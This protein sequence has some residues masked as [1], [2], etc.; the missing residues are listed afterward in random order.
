LVVKSVEVDQRVNYL[1]HLGSLL[2]NRR[3][4]AYAPK[5]IDSTFVWSHA[6]S[7][8]EQ[9]RM[10]VWTDYLRYRAR[11]RGFDLAEMESIVR[12]SSKRY[13]DT[14]TGR[15]VVVGRHGALLVMV[16]YD[17]RGEDIIPVTMHATTR[18]QINLR[19]KSGRFR[20]GQDAHDIL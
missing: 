18:Q 4:I 7:R 19:V 5:Q 8:P 3:R 20:H 10:I 1:G 12:F 17:I 13:F 11:L 15:N 14:I 16:P 6:A 2:D 9:D